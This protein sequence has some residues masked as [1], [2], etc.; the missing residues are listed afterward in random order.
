MCTII[1]LR[2]W[3]F[4]Y[5][6]KTLQP[7]KKKGSTFHSGCMFYKDYYM[8]GTIE[9]SQAVVIYDCLF[10]SNQTSQLLS[11]WEKKDCFN[12]KLNDIP[13]F[14]NL[15]D[16]PEEIKERITNG[17]W[18][19][20]LYGIQ[21]TKVTNEKTSE[22]REF[23]NELLIDIE[24]DLLVI[25][26]IFTQK[27]SGLYLIV[28]KYE[29]ISFLMLFNQLP[30]DDCVTLQSMT[31]GIFGTSIA[32][33]S[34]FFLLTKFLCDEEFGLPIFLK[35]IRSAL[36]EERTH[37]RDYNSVSSTIILD[38]VQKWSNLLFNHTSMSCMNK[39]RVQPLSVVKTILLYRKSRHGFTPRKKYSMDSL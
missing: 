36:P 17:T 3:N 20:Y 10:Q 7:L 38:N 9:Q 15:C 8:G 4:I 27:S 2:L 12:Y 22:S 33:S 1:N 13:C 34:W 21:K 23:V 37:F 18:I 29:D 14:Y 24:K 5:Q 35:T 16:Q 30:L 39:N 19:G 26:K 25:P 28:F 11:G 32:L 31:Q 6:L